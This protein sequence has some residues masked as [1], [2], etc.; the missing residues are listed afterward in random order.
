MKL[1]GKQE[2]FVP[3]YNHYWPDDQEFI[4]GLLSF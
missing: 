1:G 4:A 2:H 3:G